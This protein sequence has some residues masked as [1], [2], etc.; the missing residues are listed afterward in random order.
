[1]LWSPGD[2][3]GVQG[4]LKGVLGTGRLGGSRGLERKEVCRGGR[5]LEGCRRDW[6]D[7]GC[8]E[9]EGCRVAPRHRDLSQGTRPHGVGSHAAL[10]TPLAPQDPAFASPPPVAAPAKGGC[11][12]RTMLLALAEH[13]GI[14]KSA[15]AVPAQKAGL[16]LADEPQGCKCAP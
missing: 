2:A 16:P 13:L 1:M 12:E 6:G 4:K 15:S 11:G 8:K 3:A 14:T 9:G 7:E 10:L 5:V